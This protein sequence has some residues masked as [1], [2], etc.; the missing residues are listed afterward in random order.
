MKKIKLTHENITNSFDFYNNNLG[1]IF[2]DLE[3]KNLSYQLIKIIE[4]DNIIKNK[5][6]SYDIPQHAL[7]LIYF[8]GEYKKAYQY[9]Q[10][11]K[12]TKNANTL[13]SLGKGFPSKEKEYKK[14]LEKI[15]DDSLDVDERL[16][17]F[18]KN[19][20]FLLLKKH[21]YK[22]VSMLML[23][24]V[25]VNYPY[26]KTIV[27]N[28]HRFDSFFRLAIKSI[29]YTLEYFQ[30]THLAE[31]KI[32]N[33]SLIMVYTILTTNLKMDNDKAFKYSKELVNSFIDTNEYQTN[34]YRKNYLTDKDIYYAGIYQGM[35]IYQW[36]ISTKHTSYYEEKD[37]FKM[38]VIMRA[39]GINGKKSFTETFMMSSILKLIKKKVSVQNINEMYGSFNDEDEMKKIMQLSHIQFALI[40][41]PLLQYLPRRKSLLMLIIS[42]IIG[43][44][45]KFADLKTKL[46]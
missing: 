44:Y 5:K 13:E 20:A 36:Y 7:Y 30:Y 15:L 18:F 2:S 24:I 1:K 43:I 22:K 45:T 42:S 35:P 41:F 17:S 23:G 31:D 29:D 34:K 19:M 32:L 21:S 38:K 14:G 27:G 40:P 10:Q 28:I 39:L 26:I 6:L 4:H 16:K 33:S 3:T 37:I 46:T 11:D 9:A 12:K 8:I 25:Q